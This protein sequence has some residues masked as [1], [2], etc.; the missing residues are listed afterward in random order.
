MK[1]VA[2]MQNQWVKDPARLQAMIDRA[3]DP[4]ERRRGF[5]TTL[6]FMGCVTGRR[7]RTYLGRDLCGQIIWEEASREITGSASAKVTADLVHIE[8]VISQEKPDVI[9]TFGSIARDALRALPE[10]VTEEVRCVASPHPAARNQL[11]QARFREA[12]QLVV[13]IAREL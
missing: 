10:S 6:L 12:M 8:R 3:P 11:D 4:E 2:F 13:K 5:I 9:I 1:I 7:L